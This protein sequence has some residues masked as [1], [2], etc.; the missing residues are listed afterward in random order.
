MARKRRQTLLLV[1]RLLMA[2]VFL[3]EGADKFSS[4]R[5]W[6]R[7]FNEIGWG[8]WFRYFTGVVEIIGALLL[9]VPLTAWVGAA[10]LICTMLGAL[11]VHLF[12][13]GVGR[14]TIAVVVLMSILTV[15]AVGS[16]RRSQTIPPDANT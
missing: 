3:A 8:Q 12:V 14:Q 11:M 5:L 7:V 2:L 4:S 1:A 9:L 13:M 10:L 16:R 15:V 6:I